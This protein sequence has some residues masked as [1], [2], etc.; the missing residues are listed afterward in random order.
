MDRREIE[1]SDEEIMRRIHSRDDQR[2]SDRQFANRAA[3]ILQNMALERTGWRG[4]FGR[5]W[6]ISDEPLRNDAANLLREAGIEFSCLPKGTQMV[7]D[8]QA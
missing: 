7:G 3:G 5:R 6:H 4:L 2:M 8:D 1:M